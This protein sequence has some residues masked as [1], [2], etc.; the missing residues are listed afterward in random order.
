MPGREQSEGGKKGETAVWTPRS[1]KEQGEEV[2]QVPKQRFPCSPWRITLEQ[3]ST[4]QSVDNPMPEHMNIS[5]RTSV[6]G[7]LTQEERKSVKRKEWQ[8]GGAMDWLRAPIPHLPLAFEA[9]GG[10][11][12]G[13]EG[14][15]LNPEEGGGKMLF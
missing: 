12:D 5:W 7:E 1:E 6:P 9:G 4:L 8:R 13:N 3:M 14:V 2:L 10:R 15:K 11:G